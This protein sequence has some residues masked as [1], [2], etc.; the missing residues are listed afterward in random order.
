MLIDTHAH[1]DYPEFQAD[2]D[3][4]L[5]NARR[6]G[7]TRILS[8]GTGLSASER[9]IEL[10]A[11]HPEVF[12]VPGI[13][14]N[15]VDE[16]PEDFLEAL[17]ALA[18]RPRVAAIGE[19]GLDYFRFP[20]DG[21]FKSGQ[22]VEEAK[23]KQA[24]YFRLQLD[25]AVE[26]GLN[27][28]IHQRASWDDTVAILSEYTGRLRAVFHCFGESLE[29]A[30]RVLE[31]GHL[32]SFT[33]IATFKNGDNVRD[34]AKVL[35]PGQFMVETDCPYLAPVPFRGQRCEPAH[36]RLVANILAEVR[37]ESIEEFARHTTQT[38]ETFF[39]L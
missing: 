21:V 16:E 27:V 8:I 1:L 26:L 39:R 36:T 11:A 17:R 5:A 25:L 35:N 30:L 3:A 38:A 14:P 6:E 9:A 12:A 13:H 7:V 32:V 37:G 34:V 31:M 29:R 19:T 28:V 10:A 15:A 22:T 33:G 18:K 24:K 20:K 2:F 23:A 4:V